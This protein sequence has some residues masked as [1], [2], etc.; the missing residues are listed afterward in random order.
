MVLNNEMKNGIFFF[1]ENG[2]N[3]IE[4]NRWAQTCMFYF[5]YM[6]LPVEV[7]QE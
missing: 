5:P 2:Q 1:C 7:T 4:L 3:N 6:L